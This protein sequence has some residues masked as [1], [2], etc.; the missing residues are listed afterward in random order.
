MYRLLLAGGQARAAAIA[1]RGRGIIV[2]A[3]VAGHQNQFFSLCQPLSRALALF[4]MVRT[5]RHSY[6]AF[7][8][9][10]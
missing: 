5:Q 8:A 2:I 7:A 6:A 4:V 1:H 9:L 3:V 10:R